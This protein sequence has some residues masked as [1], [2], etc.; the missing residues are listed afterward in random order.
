M[1][2]DLQM[3]QADVLPAWNVDKCQAV[4]ASAVPPDLAESTVWSLE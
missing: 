4:K 2:L 3:Q 1:R